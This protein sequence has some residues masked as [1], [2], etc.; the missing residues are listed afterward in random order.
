MFIS[1]GGSAKSAAGAGAAATAA[2]AGGESKGD[3]RNVRIAGNKRKKKVSD[4]PVCLTLSSDEDDDEDEG[5]VGT[6]G[7]ET[8]TGAEGEKEKSGRTT[9]R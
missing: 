9:D 3:L 1:Q 6:E 2:A 7:G 8:A 5:E 4:E